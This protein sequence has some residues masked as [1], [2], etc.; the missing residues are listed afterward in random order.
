MYIHVDRMLMN[1]SI[2]SHGSNLA[3]GQPVSHKAACS[4]ALKTHPPTAFKPCL[5]LPPQCCTVYP[6]DRRTQVQLEHNR[7][8]FCTKAPNA[9]TAATCRRSSHKAL[10]PA[11]RAQKQGGRERGKGGG[12]TSPSTLPGAEVSAE[13]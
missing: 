6:P 11:S 2:F 5:P 1:L 7:A 8:L 13:A 12:R 3:L 9:D 10:L 4:P